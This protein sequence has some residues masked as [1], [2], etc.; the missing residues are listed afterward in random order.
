VA[1]TAS[2]L[3]V[4]CHACGSLTDDVIALAL[5]AEAPV[6]VL[7]C[8]HDHVRCDDAELSGWMPADLA[9]DAARAMRLRQ[10]GY[11]VWTRTIP[12][13]V[14]P[15]N[16]LLIGAPGGAGAPGGPAVPR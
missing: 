6:A 15:K 2:D 14:T 9:I 11:R 5:A 13:A 4:A 10:H 16:R 12:A 3:V 1:L 8:C 7:P